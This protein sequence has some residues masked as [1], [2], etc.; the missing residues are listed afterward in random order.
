[1]DC[2]PW[3]VSADSIPKKRNYQ[4]GTSELSDKLGV[5]S[6]GRLR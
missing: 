2:V 6:A 1:M 3:S 5:E 4:T